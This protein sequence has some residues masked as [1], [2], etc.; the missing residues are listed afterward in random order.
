[1]TSPDW[2]WRDTGSGPGHLQRI[3]A[4]ARHSRS[5]DAYRVYLDHCAG[6]TACR[7]EPVLCPDGERLKGVWRTA[8]VEGRAS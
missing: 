1:M 7:T 8:W 5:R 2:Q 4:N 3:A 6:C